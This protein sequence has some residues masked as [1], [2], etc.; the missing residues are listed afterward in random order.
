MS[1]ITTTKKIIAITTI[2]L[3]SVGFANAQIPNASST[4]LNLGHK[5]MRHLNT[6]EGMKMKGKH[7]K[8]A[9]NKQAI[10]EA[11]TA[12]NFTEF[13]KL[14]STTPMAKINQTTFNSLT[15]HFA[16]LKNARTNIESILKAAGIEKPQMG[17]K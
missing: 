6:N 15:P 14:A 2:S 17:H 10:H 7:E 5:L 8:R 11:I 4:Q 1:Q 3:G 9:D 16:A 12:G 13:Q